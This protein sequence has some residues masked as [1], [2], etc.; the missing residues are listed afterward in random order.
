MHADPEIHPDSPPG[1]E[2][3]RRL[4]R[5]APQ[6][7]L[8]ATA[9]LVA[10]Q[11]VL[12]L[13]LVLALLAAVLA[14]SQIQGSQK[15]A[16]ESPSLEPFAASAYFSSVSDD[17]REVV[18]LV[19]ISNPGG[20]QTIKVDFALVRPDGNLVE[21]AVRAVC[22]L[23]ASA[24]TLCGATLGIDPDLPGG[25]YGVWVAAYDQSGQNFFAS[26]S[27]PTWRVEI[28]SIPDPQG[29]DAENDGSSDENDWD[30]DDWDDYY[31][32]HEDTARNDWRQDDSIDEAE[33]GAVAPTLISVWA[34]HEPGIRPFYLSLAF[35][36]DGPTQEIAIGLSLFEPDSGLVAFDHPISHCTVPGSA[37]RTCLEYI[38]LPYWVEGG[39][40]QIW[41]TLWDQDSRQF[42]ALRAGSSWTVSVPPFEG[43]LMCS[44]INDELYSYVNPA[45]DPELLIEIEAN[46][47][48][49]LAW[50]EQAAWDCLD[51]LWLDD[52]KCLSSVVTDYECSTFEFL[53]AGASVV[54]VG[55]IF[56]VFKAGDEIG[57]LF[58]GD[59][60]IASLKLND[61]GMEA[62]RKA[63][64]ARVLDRAAQLSEL[65]GFS[66]LDGVASDLIGKPNA[67]KRL[68]TLMEVGG[69]GCAH[70]AP[71]SGAWNQ[72]VG[73]VGEL[74]ALSWAKKSG[75][76]IES[77][78]D[79]SSD[80]F[81]FWND[82]TGKVEFKVPDGLSIKPTGEQIW[83]ESRTKCC[84]SS[85]FIRAKAKYAH[86][87]AH[88]CLRIVVHASL[89]SAAP[90][91]ARTA[92]RIENITKEFGLGVEIVDMTSATP[93][94][95][96]NTCK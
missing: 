47:G 43:D 24:I 17:R 20:A 40:Y 45:G 85:A 23:R 57:H 46:D 49:L 81:G 8:H 51:F 94:V 9:P 25:D 27:N 90:V 70:H 73:A 66:K 13:T 14:V 16:A 74:K 1:S 6:P 86:A 88:H 60:S 37:S 75:E 52:L 33:T 3:V 79:N 92:K 5:S 59:D 22:E 39:E 89:S 41:V 34:E 36:N 32:G 2:R 55:K 67:L 64:G 62:L 68:E 19:S 71:R 76:E 96:K 77:V 31:Q 18:A 69:K 26:W 28:P 78:F 38:E 91:A 12:R 44:V 61:A 84:L 48:G 65:P 4:R 93:K 29:S 83:N 95:A 72:C 63:D 50:V 80:Y 56:K 42:L 58:K 10:C 15:A 7:S 11:G 82:V 87:H 30:G 53:L 21:D 35:E 54:P